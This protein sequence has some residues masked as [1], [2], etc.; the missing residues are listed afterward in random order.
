[1]ARLFAL[2]FTAMSLI[3]L[4][5]TAGKTLT[6]LGVAPVIVAWTRFAIA[7]VLLLPFSGLTRDELRVFLD[8]RLWLRAAL[9]C[10]GIVSILSALRT[11]PIADVFGVFFIGPVVSYVLSALLLKEAVTRGRSMLLG[12]GFVGVL[13]VV[14]PGFGVAPG[15]M[16]A[17]LAGVFYG[18]YLTATRWLAPVVRPRLLLLSQLLIGAVLLAPLGLSGDM[19]PLDVS[20]TSLVIVALIV[21]S[22]VC[23]AL[24]NFILV[25]VSRTTP[26]SLVSPLIYTQLVAAT[27]A[28]LVFFGDLPDAIAM[29]GLAL[30]LVSGL[31]SL[32]LAQDSRERR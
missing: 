22:A 28:G 18:A 16:L 11:E 5:D 9:I 19:P 25:T 4:G 23:S 21:A 20:K 24:G 31:A 7:A 1:M 27:L 32:Y 3:V 30:I 17:L 8:W 12:L 2:V 6:G 14:K 29:A 10:G 13:L 15:L 26:G